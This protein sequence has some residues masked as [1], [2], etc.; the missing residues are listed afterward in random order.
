MA[1]TQILVQ[2]GGCPEQGFRGCLAD[3]LNQSLGSSVT[4]ATTKR[5]LTKHYG[6]G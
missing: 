2:T 3:R 6:T 4:Q 5:E 1:H